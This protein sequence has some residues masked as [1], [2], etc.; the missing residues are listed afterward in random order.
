MARLFM[1]ATQLP[2]VDENG[3]V[4]YQPNRYQLTDR[5]L[6]FDALMVSMTNYQARRR[7]EDQK[8]S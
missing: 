6:D 8:P 7:A 3:R 1:M 4:R 2:E 5:G